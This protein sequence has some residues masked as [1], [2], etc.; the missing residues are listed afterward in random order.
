MTLARR[1]RYIAVLAC[2]L[3][4]TSAHQR[5]S[6]VAFLT[7]QLSIRRIL[8]HLGLSTPPQDRPPPVREILRVGEH[9][10][11]WGVSAEWDR[12][13]STRVGGPSP[14]TGSPAQWRAS[15]RVSR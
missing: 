14:G 15:S 6:V 1:R 9:G 12:A 4:V 8:D 13:P 2:A 3:A 10:D 11:G 7:D 5:M